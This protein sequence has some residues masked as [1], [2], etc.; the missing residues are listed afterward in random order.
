ME[1]YVLSKELLIDLVET[2]LA[3]GRDHF[4]RHAILSRLQQL[5]VHAYMHDGVLGVV[6]NIA[7]YYRHSME[8]LQPAFGASCS[9]SPGAIYTKVKDEPPTHYRDG[10]RRQR[11]HSSRTAAISKAP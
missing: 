8:L 3:Q 4:V 9:S 10:R 2:S 5:H 7:A 11:I 1:M 6:N